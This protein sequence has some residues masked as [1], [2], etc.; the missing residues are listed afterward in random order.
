MTTGFQD[1]LPIELSLGLLSII[2]S[3]SLVIIIALTILHAEPAIIALFGYTLDGA[4][5][6]VFHG[7][8]RTCTGTVGKA[9]PTAILPLPLIPVEL[10]V[11]VIKQQDDSGEESDIMNEQGH[12]KYAG[13]HYLFQKPLYRSSRYDDDKTNRY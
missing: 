6:P 5:L 9:A 10:E 4:V 1:R 11:N 8:G 7:C 13:W 3:L 12:I 2:L